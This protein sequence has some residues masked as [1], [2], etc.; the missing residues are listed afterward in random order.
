MATVGKLTQQGELKLS[1]NINTRLPLVTDGLI[2]H[3]PMDG[4][5]D[6]YF[7][8]TF[9]YI[10]HWKNGSTANTGNHWYEIKAIGYDNVNYALN[11]PVTGS[12]SVT[13][14]AILTDGST[15][16]GSYTS[17]ADGAL[18][19]VQIDMGYEYSI[20]EIGIW[21]Y[22][23]DSRTYYETKLDVSEDGIT[24][25]TIFDSAIEGTYQA[26][27]AGKIIDLQN[28][29]NTITPT[30]DSNTTITTDYVAIEEG[31]TNVIPDGDFSNGL[32]Q[33][34]LSAYYGTLSI[35][36]DSELGRNVLK[37]VNTSTT[38]ESFTTSQAYPLSPAAN[39]QTWTSSIYV[40]A[41]ED[42][43]AIELFVMG[44]NSSNNYVDI[45]SS[46]K[47]ISPSDG[48]VMLT[49]TKAFTDS[50]VASVTVRLDINSYGKTIYAKDWQLEQKAFATEFVNGSRGTAN[51]QLPIQRITTGTII[52]EFIP[53]TPWKGSDLYTKTANQASLLGIH[54]VLKGGNMYY[55]YYNPNGI[56]NPFLDQDGYYGTNHY[57][58][59]V[60]I[61]AGVKTYYVI[62][63]SG[64]NLSIR[65]YQ[66]GWKDT[67][68]SIVPSD[69]GIDKLSFGTTTLWSCKHSNISQYNRVLTTSE[70][71]KIIK[72][73][74]SITADGLIS[75]HPL[76]SQPKYPSDAFYFDLGY[77][78]KDELKYVIPT[79]DTAN[80]S[81]GDAYVG[82]NSLEYN[83]NSSIG[84][85]WSG[86]WS[87]CYMKKPIGTSNGA[88]NLTGYNIESVGCNSNSV[89]GGY[90]WWGK[91]SGSNSLS[92][93]SNSTITPTDYFNNWQYI[94][95][96]KTGTSLVIETWMVDKLQRSRT[97]PITTTVPNYYVTQYGYDFKLGGWDN[98]SGCYTHFRNLVVLKRA[99][100]QDELEQYRKTKMKATKDGL[101]IQ[102]GINSGII[103]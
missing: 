14:A 35:I 68:Y 45:I 74:H 52:G 102:N 47:I 87:I 63:R 82:G 23:N 22:Y 71:E 66:N 72:G 88:T 44:L 93:T 36:F 26:T 91:T 92:G 21:D 34:Y 76:L 32:K 96:V 80:Y 77:N 59:S 16:T 73:T 95:M 84:L 19:Y 42:N 12:S 60:E 51:L 75:K 11:K 18:G 50:T 64:T 94:T 6:K 8:T 1:G 78:G 103:L 56:S 98:N 37:Y 4:T 89:G 41:T 49:T 17:I 57:H 65:L 29:G 27:S 48:W 58:A 67:H 30:I 5:T 101:Y 53:D 2:A 13:N 38:G 39:G 43:T 40:K 25:Y 100:S 31:T 15:A 83:F 10:R 46:T 28:L 79:E 86:D 85:D 20:K 3:Y 33:P 62:N 24:W 7:L 69:A 97:L 90:L 81:D 99:M 70:V 54:D 61:L 9:R 55:R